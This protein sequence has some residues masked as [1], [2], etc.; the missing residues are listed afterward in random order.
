[1]RHPR[2]I[3]LN[4]QSKLQLN[5]SAFSASSAVEMGGGGPIPNSQF[6]IPDVA[7]LLQYSSISK[8]KATFTSH[9]TPFRNEFRAAVRALCLG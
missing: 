1:M 5:N 6:P 2:T 3:I 4:L 7:F 8:P 9:S